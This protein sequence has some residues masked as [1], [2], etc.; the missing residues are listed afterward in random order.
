LLWVQLLF[1][2]FGGAARPLRLA[3]LPIASSEQQ[4]TSCS[5]TRAAQVTASEQ[6]PG[7]PQ[8]VNWHCEGPVVVG[9]VVVA[10]TVVVATVVLAIKV[11]RRSHMLN[12]GVARECTFRVHAVVVACR[13]IF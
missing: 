7:L 8:L 3:H 4:R 12:A 13:R 1:V 9:S 6:R 11:H 10:T 2:C 5:S